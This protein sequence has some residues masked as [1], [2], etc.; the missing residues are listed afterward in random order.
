MVFFTKPTGEVLTERAYAL[1]RES[2]QVV[3]ED[4]DCRLVEC[5]F[6]KDCAHLEVEYPPKVALSK[7]VNSLKGVSS[8]R[9]R[10]S[11]SAARRVSASK[12][13]GRRF[14]S[15]SYL[16]VSVSGAEEDAIQQFV[17]EQQG[18]TPCA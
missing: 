3:C 4:F 2:W 14:W 7:L 13:G 17:V 15:G 16:A 5:R 1:L 10:S 12:I 9:L 18:E 6:E 11:S 8:R